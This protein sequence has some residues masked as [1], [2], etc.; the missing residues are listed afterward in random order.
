MVVLLSVTLVGIAGGREEEPRQEE[1][2]LNQWIEKLEHEDVEV[3]RS[4]ARALQEMGP[5]AKEAV[6]VLVKALQDKDELVRTNAGFAL[7][8]VGPEAEQAIPNLI[9]TLQDEVMIV[10]VGAA[11]GLGG[12]GPR[13]KK[14]IPALAEVLQ[15]P[16]EDHNVLSRAAE[17]LGRMG[18]ESIPV[19][20]GGLQSENYFVRRIS[21]RALGAVGAGGVPDLVK[22]LEDEDRNVRLI[23]VQTLGRIGPEAK[24][25]VPALTKA[26][27]DERYKVRTSATRALWL[28][29]VGIREARKS[30]TFPHGEVKDGLAAF[31]F[32]HKN[33]FEV[34]EP[35]PLT[36]GI[37]LVGPGLSSKDEKAYRLKAKVRRPLEAMDPGNG[38]WFEVVGPDGASVSY[39]GGYDDWPEG[40]PPPSHT[41]ILGYG[42]FLGRTH[43][44]LCKHGAFD[45]SRPGRYMVRWCYGPWEDEGLW[46]GK[47]ISNE[48]QV[49]IVAE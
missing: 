10:R 1:K 19:L 27:Q 31:L 32:C 28:I 34:G 33:R 43:S 49:E 36:H 2:T 3:R 30:C 37:I 8:R 6:P 9:E 5:G 18:P 40:P 48:V 24:Q 29:S 23:A 11:G 25:S 42:E 45:L 12:I 47:L 20:A 13:A 14:A 7:G 15:N 22:A 26:L 4:A 46:V 35:I 21:T 17:A 39:K 41:A 38:S 44:D 16:V